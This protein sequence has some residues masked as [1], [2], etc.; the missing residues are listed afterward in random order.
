[1]RTTTLI[2]LAALAVVTTTTIPACTS[3]A[4]RAGE[5]VPFPVGYRDWHHVK[6]MLIQ[7]GHA[8]Y[9]AFGGIHHVYAN[10][11]A[12]AGLQTGSYADG[13]VFAFD[14]LDVQT[15]DHAVQ[16]G[17]RKVLGVMH[18]SAAA[19]PATGGWGFAGFDAAG[20]DVVK[21][22]RTQC[23]QCH[24]ARRDHGFVF[25]QLRP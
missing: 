18:R 20:T 6:S 12:L 19:F 21:D 5:P 7:P 4:L 1:M 17:Q 23:F 11:A 3:A 25:S 24:E 22:M 13:A 16:E 2:S 9:D 8:L 14:L 15:G 10:A